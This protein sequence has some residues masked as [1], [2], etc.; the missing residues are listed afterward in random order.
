MNHTPPSWSRRRLILLLLPALALILGIFY[1]AW[2]FTKHRFPFDGSIP[3]LESTALRNTHARFT[4]R[5]SAGHSGTNPIKG[6][7]ELG[8]KEGSEAAED[9]VGV[10][11]FKKKSAQAGL[12]LYVSGHAELAVLMDMAGNTL[13]QWTYDLAAELEEPEASELRARFRRA[14]LYPNGDLLV[15][16]GG[17]SL[18]AKFDRNSK[19]LWKRRAGFHHDLEVLND[20]RILAIGSEAH[21]LE[22][23][24]PKK[25]VVEDFI[26]LL[27]AEGEILRQISVLEAFEN[28]IYA[29]ML[30]QMP[31]FGDIL[32]TNTIEMLGQPGPGAPEAWGAGMVLVS[33]REMDTI[34]VIDLDEKAVVWAMTGMW[35]GQH[36]PTV[37]DNGQMLIFDNYG[38]GMSSVFTFEPSSQEITWAYR[39]DPQNGFLSETCGSCIRL[40]NGNTLI[41][42]SDSGR[43]F[44][45]TLDN[46]VVWRFVS[47]HTAGE[48]GE[49][50]ATL[51]EVI[52]YPVDYA[53]AWL[54]P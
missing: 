14:H 34:A 46:Q 3:G 8:Y 1:G 18:I 29:P 50:V 19:L 53:A 2:S 32:H 51:F 7:E 44:E 42:E 43:A 49:L 48:N 21:V 35:D 45:V 28:S 26:T 23:I 47:P 11:I 41:T 39:G 38:T 13:H 36:Q 22:R 52:R 10:V 24:H 20:G 37:L 54:Q 40:E 33:V 27:S 5:K 9:Q 31:A 30:Q 6:L 12:N 16:Y 4:P 17:H 15:V 25:L